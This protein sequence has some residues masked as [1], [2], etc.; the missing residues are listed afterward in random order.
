MI[1][2]EKSCMSADQDLGTEV[3]VKLLDEGTD[4]WRPVLAERQSDGSFRLRP[5]E[6]DDLGTEIWEFP[7]NTRV[8]C[9]PRT[10]SDGKRAL[11]AV[12]EV[13]LSK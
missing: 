9:E 6:S 11:V 12:A 2:Q 10:F 3:Y 7:P 5:P 4:V 8:K 13:K 1:T